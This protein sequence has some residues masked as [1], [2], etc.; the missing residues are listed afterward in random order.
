MKAS[1]RRR[2]ARSGRRPAR[3]RAKAKNGKARIE[4]FRRKDFIS[5]KKLPFAVVWSRPAREKELHRHDFEEIVVVVSGVG[6][7]VSQDG[8]WPVQS[9]SV[10]VV[11]DTE[12]HYYD[13]LHNLVLVNVLFD[14]RRLKMEAHDIDSMEGFKALFA[15]KGVRERK[16]HRRQLQ[17]SP[18][19]VAIVLNQVEALD[20]EIES[21]RSGYVYFAHLHFFTLVGML[22]RLWPEKTDSPQAVAL[23]RLAKVI[24]HLEERFH[25]QHSLP[26]L[27]RLAGMS[28]RNLL[29]FF[30]LATGHGPHA[31]LMQIRLNRAAQALGDPS[32][33]ITEVALSSGFQDSG[34]FSRQFRK[35]MGVAPRDYRAQVCQIN[36]APR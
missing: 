25:E 8:T 10:F 28:E 18:R 9:G 33:S 21:K 4:V 35:H 14:R 11:A 32:R 16:R 23:L 17:L 13:D 19:E 7:H 31:H 5:D 30:H 2:A 24:E 6:M 36:G 12:A 3:S 22:A 1:S 20:Q 26:S 15:P 34:Y 27:A 29:R